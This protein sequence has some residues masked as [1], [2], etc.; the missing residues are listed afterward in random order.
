MSNYTHPLYIFAKALPF[1]GEWKGRR[2]TPEWQRPRDTTP[3]LRPGDDFTCPVCGAGWECDA[4]QAPGY[5]FLCPACETWLTWRAVRYEEHAAL[6]DPTCSLCRSPMV[7]RRGKFGAFWGCS[8]WAKTK[9][10]GKQGPRV[11]VVEV[12]AVCSLI[13]WKP[14]AEWEPDTLRAG[15]EK[16][17]VARQAIVERQRGKRWKKM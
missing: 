14:C 3:W 12:V 4:P 17:D 16:R 9:C 6:G 2:Y 5:R 8:T 10:R 13:I 15:W 1:S 7:R 11:S